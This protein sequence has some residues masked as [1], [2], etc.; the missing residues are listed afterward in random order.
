LMILPW[1]RLFAF[2]GLQLV[3]AIAPI[4]VLPVVV[5]HHLLEPAIRTHGVLS[6]SDALTGVDVDVDVEVN[7]Y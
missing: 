4:L 2:G 3:G 1:K 6:E 7:G 5:R